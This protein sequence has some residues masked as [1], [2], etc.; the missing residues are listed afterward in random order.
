MHLLLSVA[1]FVGPASSATAPSLRPL[2]D[3][4]RALTDRYDRLQLDMAEMRRRLRHRHW[5]PV[6]RV[7]ASASAWDRLTLETSQESFDLRRQGYAISASIEFR[8]S[9]IVIDDQELALERERWHAER[10]RDELLLRLHERYADAEAALQR[11]AE[12]AA[13]ER[14]RLHA[15]QAIRLLEATALGRTHAP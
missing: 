12:G 15:V 2:A 10:A 5:V 9:E 8:F 13:T 1:L 4:E 6:V 3:Y 14:E 11:L 7:Q